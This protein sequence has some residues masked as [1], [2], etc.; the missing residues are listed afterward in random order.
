MPRGR[1][2]LGNLTGAAA[3]AWA[4]GQVR[5]GNA[6]RDRDIVRA[7]RSQAAINRGTGVYN[8]GNSRPGTLQGGARN[9]RSASIRITPNQF[10]VLN[11]SV[12]S[13]NTLRQAAEDARMSTRQA[14]RALGRST[15]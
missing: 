12:R 11:A 10:T 6:Q 4:Q 8:Y 15:G 3:R 1:N 2:S 14:R 5:R 7:T 9:A 13:G